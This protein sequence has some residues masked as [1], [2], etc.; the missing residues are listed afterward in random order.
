MSWDLHQQDRKQPILPADMPLRM[1]AVDIQAI[2]LQQEEVLL[3]ERHLQS[4]TL[5]LEAVAAVVVAI[6]VE[7]VEQEDFY[8][9]LPTLYQQEPIH[10][11]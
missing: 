7:A 2:Y 8:Q 11:L 1:L 3:L 4:T 6:A 5:L 9:V 10:S